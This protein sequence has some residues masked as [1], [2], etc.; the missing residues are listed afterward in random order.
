MA[1]C[2]YNIPNVYVR[3]A[4]LYGIGHQLYVTGCVCIYAIWKHSLGHVNKL[5]DTSQQIK[6]NL[7]TNHLEQCNH[8]SIVYAMVCTQCN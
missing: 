4:I 6:Y 8:K 5:I 3:Y 7:T 2:T 1:Y